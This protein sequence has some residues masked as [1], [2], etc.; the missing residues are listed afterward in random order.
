MEELGELRSSR[1]RAIRVD[2]LTATL[3][4]V[5][6]RGEPCLAIKLAARRTFVYEATVVRIHVE[7]QLCSCA[8]RVVGAVDSRKTPGAT[9]GLGGLTKDPHEAGKKLAKDF[10]AAVGATDQ[11]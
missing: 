10:G 2:E 5:R 7:D 1:P 6:E 8:Q 9:T 3:D 11:K 4:E